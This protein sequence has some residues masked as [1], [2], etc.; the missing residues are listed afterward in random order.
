MAAASASAA[1][2]VRVSTV[3]TPPENRA[4]GYAQSCVEALTKRILSQS[5]R[6]ALFADL[7]NP[8]ANAVYRRIGY[9]PVTEMLTYRLGA[10]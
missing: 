9:Q 5:H 2:V 3:Y 6:C 4:R 8:T 1:G 7:K 10:E